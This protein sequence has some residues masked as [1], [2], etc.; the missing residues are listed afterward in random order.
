MEL[1]AN[2]SG[3][4]LEAST[5]QLHLLPPQCRDLPRRER[6]RR[7][8]WKLQKLLN[9]WSYMYKQKSR[10]F[11]KNASELCFYSLPSLVVT[12]ISPGLSPRALGNGEA[13]LELPWLV[14]SACRPDCS[15]GALASH[16]LRARLLTVGAMAAAADALEHMSLHVLLVCL[17]TMGAFA[18]HSPAMT[19]AA[20]KA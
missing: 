20:I 12:A 10:I 5:R 8:T 7:P 3:H 18:M 4:R 15:A 2:A 17:L 1:E 19:M 9:G 16:S 13:T 14:P 6:L 11:F